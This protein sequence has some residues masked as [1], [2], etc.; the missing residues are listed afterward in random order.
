[1]SFELLCDRGLHRLLYPSDLWSIPPSAVSQCLSSIYWH[2]W[3]WQVLSQIHWLEY[4][5]PC[6]VLCCR[7]S[8]RI[9]AFMQKLSVIV[10]LHKLVVSTWWTFSPRAELCLWLFNVNVRLGVCRS[11]GVLSLCCSG[12]RCREVPGIL[13][14]LEYKSNPGPSLLTV[15]GAWPS[16]VPSLLFV[17]SYDRDKNLPRTLPKVRWPVVYLWQRKEI[18]KLWR[19]RFFEK[20]CS[21]RPSHR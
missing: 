9:S 6:P 13:N 2:S 17:C 14:H 4:S 20:R 7:H 16:M 18:F 5:E 12:T 11:I 8:W 19:K 3:F 15:S 10:S 1:M 21:L